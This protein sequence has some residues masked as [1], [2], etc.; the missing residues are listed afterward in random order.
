[1][2]ALSPIEK[3]AIATLSD[4]PMLAQV[5]DW[6]RINSGTRNLAGVAVMA[7]KLGDA[8]APLPGRI[9]LA[10]PAPVTSVGLDGT[11]SDLVHG[12]HFHLTVRPDAPVQMLFTGHMDTVYP[13]DHPFQAL[14][15]LADGTLNG[16][17]VA[18]MKGGLSVMLAAL[19]AV[20][21]SPLAGRIGYEAVIN[22]DEE[23]GSSSSSALLAQAARGKIAALTYEPALPDG[24][25]AGARGGTGNFSIV[26]HGKSAHAGR[27]PDEGRNAIVAAADIA[28]RLSRVRGPGLA[29]NPA[30]IEGGG[31]NNVVPDLAIL[32][33]NFRPAAQEEIARAQAAVDSVVAAVAAEHD[34][35]IQV[36]GGFNRPPKPID[37]G[38]A[39]LF[40]LVKSAGADLG[41]DLSW[42]A[43]GGVCDGNNIAACGVP[44]V[45]TMGARGGAIH[46]SDEFLIVDSLAERAALSALTVLRIAEKGSL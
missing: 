42:R 10:E 44:V 25:L 17:G 38:A 8:F 46:S 45:D 18:D 13:V 27:N 15:F 7:G 12:R 4:A 30:R 6:A 20:E 43:T 9:E 23:T 33:V 39:K 37:P 19:K 24:T 41:L 11:V 2:T 5:Q 16:P 1:M 34:V 31:P 14:T 32:R 28:L 22:S 29:V 3:D 21:A 26:V 36:H 35:R 40:E